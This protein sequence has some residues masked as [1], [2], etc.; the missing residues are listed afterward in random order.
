MTP[1][2]L[3]YLRVNAIAAALVGQLSG[4]KKRPNPAPGG[5]RVEASLS[6]GAL[7][8]LC[9]SDRVTRM[10]DIAAPVRARVVASLTFN[11]GQTIALGVPVDVPG[12]WNASRFSPEGHS[13]P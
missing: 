4:L 2:V 11:G 5:G 9:T 6:P 12:R 1:P 13:V 8:P 7:V 10:D 3:L